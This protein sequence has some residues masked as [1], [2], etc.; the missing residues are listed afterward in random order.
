MLDVR[1]KRTG[2]RTFLRTTA[3]LPAAGA[4]A[5]SASELGT[6][7]TGI[8]GTGVQGQLLL[9][10]I[11]PNY[12]NV[13]AVCDIHPVNREAGL[14][15]VHDLN[16]SEAKA[17]KSYQDVLANHEIEAVIIAA[18]LWL[19]APTAI[20]ALNAG[21]HVFCETAM[22]KTMDECRAMNQAASKNN[23]VLQIGHQRFY[24]P[25]YH[26]GH[27]IIKSGLLGEI[28]HVRALWHQNNN[29]KRRI[30]RED[31]RALSNGF[32]PQSH[33]YESLNHLVNWR[34]YVNYS[35]GLASELMTHQ[36]ACVN[37]FLGATPTNVFASGGTYK[38]TENDRSVPDHIF[39][40][41]AYPNNCTLTYSA[42]QTNSHDEYYEMYM[43]TQGTLIMSGETQSYLFWESGFEPDL[44]KRATEM[45]I[46]NEAAGPVGAA[47]PTQQPRRSRLDEGRQSE[48]NNGMNALEPYR[49][50]LEGFAHAIRAGAPVLCN[51]ETAMTA[52]AAAFAANQAI[53]SEQKER[54]N[55]A[56]A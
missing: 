14:R 43:G 10:Q 4:L 48:E 7:N 42:I 3:A 31:E 41:F 13:S 25:V 28:Y 30:T 12:L 20:A 51:G 18:P 26:D 49:I 16:N 9:K 5:W 2:R 50:E 29:W 6:I 19:H 38:Y 32:S 39:C 35:G 46:A 34:L 11:N 27:Q 24:N 22:A 37:W 33:E 21:K 44:A 52:A 55:T 53:S 36:I 15:T 23:R 56:I 47:G 45:S 8:I 40:T 1:Q 54:I 17:Y